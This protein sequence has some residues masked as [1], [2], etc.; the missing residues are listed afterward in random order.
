MVA[1]NTLA[2]V[3]RAVGKIKAI[4]SGY[5][6]TDWVGALRKATAAY[7]ERSHSYLMG[8]APQDVK[9]SAK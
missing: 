9:G 2:L 1:A 4:L 5:S 7:N 8:S 6:L 3:D